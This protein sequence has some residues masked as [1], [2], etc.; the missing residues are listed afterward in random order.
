[1]YNTYTLSWNFHSC[2]I[3]RNITAVKRL[4]WISQDAISIR[5]QMYQL[6]KMFTKKYILNIVNKLPIFFWNLLRI[7]IIYKVSSQ[8][9]TIMVQETLFFKIKCGDTKYDIG[10]KLYS[11]IFIWLT[12]VWIKWKH[13]L[14]LL[15]K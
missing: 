7:F 2:E 4:D 13:F 5:D 10:C 14:Q 6:L 3:I 8:K 1:M 11:L 9:E 12:C 15:K